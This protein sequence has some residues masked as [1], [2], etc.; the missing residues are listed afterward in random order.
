[1]QT[2]DRGQQIVAHLATLAS[3]QL[4]AE[5]PGDPAEQLEQFRR[6]LETDALMSKEED[7]AEHVEAAN[8]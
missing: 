2:S 5:R 1:M 4:I 3:I 6:V 8:A 7:D